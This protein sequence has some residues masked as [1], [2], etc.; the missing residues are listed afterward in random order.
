MRSAQI[1]QASCGEL[2]KAKA[3]DK[4]LAHGVF[5]SPHL[6][7]TWRALYSFVQVYK[8]EPLSTLVGE[9]LEKPFEVVWAYRYRLVI[10][11][12][13]NQNALALLKHARTKCIYI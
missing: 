13:V 10:C 3:K 5:A 11:Q 4:A 6:H 1:E 8:F 7:C 9:R 2:E 12:W